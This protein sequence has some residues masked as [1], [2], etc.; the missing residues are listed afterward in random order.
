MCTRNKSIIFWCES[1][2]CRKKLQ[3]D[4]VLNQVTPFY[5]LPCCCFI[6]YCNNILPF[7]PRFSKQ[8]LSFRVCY[9]NVLC[10]SLRCIFSPRNCVGCYRSHSVINSYSA[11]LYLHKVICFMSNGIARYMQN[12]VF[13][14]TTFTVLLLSLWPGMFLLILSLAVFHV[15]WIPYF[16]LQKLITEILITT[17]VK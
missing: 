16:S 15:Y 1:V 3:H 13:L 8:F 4:F 17:H 9:Q 11:V 2:T 14:F 7:T 5:T 12:I 10:I 6:P